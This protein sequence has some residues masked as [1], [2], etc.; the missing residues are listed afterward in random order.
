MCSAL[1]GIRR[2]RRAQAKSKAMPKLK[3]TAQPCSSIPAMP[4]I[5]MDDEATHKGEPSD[6]IDVDDGDATDAGDESDYPFGFCPC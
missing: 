4:D 1:G 6:A 2:K 3:A 5:V